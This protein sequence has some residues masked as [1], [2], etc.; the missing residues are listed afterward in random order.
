MCVFV[1]ESK[2]FGYQNH[3]FRRTVVASFTQLLGEIKE[4]IFFSKGISPKVNL[5][6]RLEFE[7]AFSD[8]TVQRI[9][10][11]S[12]VIPFNKYLPFNLV[13]G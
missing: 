3:P 5:I 7:L 2:Y 10:H 9:H 8:V 12:T 1:C 6:L 11:Y 13:P 4:I